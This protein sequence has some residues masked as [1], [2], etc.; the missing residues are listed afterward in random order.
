M[1]LCI[2]DI[3]DVPRDLIIVL[4]AILDNLDCSNRD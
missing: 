2:C 4:H 1:H 3:K